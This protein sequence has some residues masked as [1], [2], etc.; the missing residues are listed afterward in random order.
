M[1][2]VATCFTLPTQIPPKGV[3][4]IWYRGFPVQKTVK[5]VRQHFRA[6]E[7]SEDTLL[8]AVIELVV[9]AMEAVGGSVFLGELG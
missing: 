9:A 1:T 5:H 7:E 2:L 8:A 4:R 6:E 3:P